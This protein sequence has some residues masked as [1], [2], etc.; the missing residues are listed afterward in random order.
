MKIRNDFVTNSSSSSFI[1]SL[2]DDSINLKEYI[3]KHSGDEYSICYKL[4]NKADLFK[5]IISHDII[6]SWEFEQIESN[7]NKVD[8]NISSEIICLI[9]LANKYDFNKYYEAMK[10]LE[11][12]KTLYVINLT[13]DFM[14]YFPDLEDEIRDS[15]FFIE[16][17]E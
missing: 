16:I 7:L 12:G 11:S 15:E 13:Y 3:N 9:M 10:L 5:Y 2:K 17:E 14:S 4:N 8:I 6:S 1:I